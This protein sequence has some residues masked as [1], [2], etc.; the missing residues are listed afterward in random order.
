VYGRAARVLVAFEAEV[1]CADNF[2]M[3]RRC[4]TIC[5]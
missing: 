2:D 4:S 1:E 5:R 3:W